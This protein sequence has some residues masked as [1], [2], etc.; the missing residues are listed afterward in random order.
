FFQQFMEYFAQFKNDKNGI[1]VKPSLKET[2]ALE[3]L[4]ILTLKEPHVLHRAAWAIDR[5]LT[6]ARHRP[7]HDILMQYIED[8]DLYAFILKR[9]SDDRVIR[10]RELRALVSFI[11]LIKR[12]DLADPALGLDDFLKELELR[13]IHDMPIRGEL[14]TLS[15]DGVRIYTA[16]KS[17][18]LEF[19][20]V[21][22][23]FCLQQKS[24]PIRKKPDV[25]DLPADIYTSKERVDEKN[26]IKEL[27]LHDELRLFY[28][29]STRAKASLIY[30]ATPLEKAIISPFISGISIKQES[31]A[32]A[33]EEKFLGDFLRMETFDVSEK[34]TAD[35]LKDI[36]GN[37]TLNPTSVNNY[38]TCRRKFL[39]N[40]VLRLPGKKNQ[41]LTFGNCA[42]KA[43]EDV[44]KEFMDT[45]KFPGF[46]VFKRIFLRELEFHGIND[47]IRRGCLDKLERVRTWYEKQEASPVM[48]LELENKLE[49]Y[50]TDGLVF[51]GKFDKVEPCGDGEVKVVDYK[52]GKPDDHAKDMQNCR[53]L[54]SADC[55]DYFRQL[56]AYKLLYDKNQQKT[57]G[58]ALVTKGV[59]QFL[60]PAGSTVK[61]YGLEKGAYMDIAVDL[62]D[63]MSAELVRTIEGVWGNIKKLSFE[64]LPEKDND[65]CGFCPYA[66]ICWQ[67]E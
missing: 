34:E 11:N 9:Y 33:D 60:E 42:H 35:I 67:D 58:K 14:A 2:E 6:D 19:Y 22:I 12:S 39:Y 63:E 13:E 20:T 26:R 55:D 17:K 15:Q 30:T 38:I 27:A 51:R 21:F 5:L 23:P 64:Q 43:L 31:G 49:I 8:S 37:L 24:W 36:I 62:N 28:V 59:I 18:G 45:G 41:Q 56:V 66:D 29:A 53:D 10:V 7:V 40:D 4:N 50:M 47:A 54:S 44:Y 61:K 52:T 48:P 46:Q 25:V 32:P 16:H 3:I 1:S 65:K 57:G